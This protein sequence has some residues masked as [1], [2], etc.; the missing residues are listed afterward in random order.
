MLDLQ[1]GAELGSGALPPDGQFGGARRSREDVQ[2]ELRR[3]LVGRQHQRGG[4]VETSIRT[5]LQGATGDER[6]GELGNGTGRGL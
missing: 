6:D 1:H 5:D 3:Q 2:A 4:D